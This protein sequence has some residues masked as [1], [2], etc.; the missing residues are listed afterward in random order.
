MGSPVTLWFLRVTS[1]LF[2]LTISPLNHTVRSREQRGWFHQE[3]LTLPI[4]IPHPNRQGKKFST[5]GDKKKVKCLWGCLGGGELG[6]G[7][8]KSCIYWPIKANNLLYIQLPLSPQSVF[9][10]LATSL[11]G[12]KKILKRS[13]SPSNF[14]C[15]SHKWYFMVVLTIN[16]IWM[17]WSCSYMEVKRQVALE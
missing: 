5:S 14:M 12:G 8:S 11:I 16:Y 3:G 10:E 17:T 9:Q 2:V 6:M 7:M 13:V 1:I 15:Q 4:Q